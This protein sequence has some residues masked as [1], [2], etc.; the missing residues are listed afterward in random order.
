MPMVVT[1]KVSWFTSVMVRLFAR[2]S[3]FS[4]PNN[5]LEKP[6][7]PELMQNRATV[8]AVW[9]EID[10]YMTDEGLRRDMERT[11]GRIHEMLRCGASARAAREVLRVAGRAAN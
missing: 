7:V 6:V 2:V 1:Y 3:Y 9:K 11:L 5:L 10:R 8:D 4:M